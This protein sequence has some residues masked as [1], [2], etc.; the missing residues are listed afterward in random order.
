MILKEYRITII[1]KMGW[2]LG[3]G[4]Q[5][6]HPG[7]VNSLSLSVITSEIIITSLAMHI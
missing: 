6:S 7:Q 1:T 4:D 5:G 3:T 2:G